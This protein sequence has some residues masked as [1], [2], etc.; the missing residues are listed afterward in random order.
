M[1][2]AHV[3]EHLQSYYKIRGCVRQEGVP[4][5]SYQTVCV[6]SE[7]QCSSD[8][9]QLTQLP[10]MGIVNIKERGSPLFSKFG[11]LKQFNVVFLKCIFKEMSENSLGMGQWE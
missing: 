4:R 10:Q 11:L 5:D 3:K 7:P 1:E 8:K 2:T 6:H 9:Q